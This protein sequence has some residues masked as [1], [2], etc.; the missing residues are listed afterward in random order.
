VILFARKSEGVKLPFKT[1]TSTNKQTNK[2]TDKQTDKHKQRQQTKH[3]LPTCVSLGPRPRASPR[4]PSSHSR[5]C[6]YPS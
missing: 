1:T 2:Q 5:A 4:P 3:L 6:P